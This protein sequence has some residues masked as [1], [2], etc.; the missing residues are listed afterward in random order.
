M[1]TQEVASESSTRNLPVRLFEVLEREIVAIDGHSPSP[2]SWLL[3]RDHIDAAL[4]TRTGDLLITDFESR[5][6][7]GQVLSTRADSP[8]G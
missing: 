6:T 3:E 7:R 8:W 1:A 2:P 4:L 5:S